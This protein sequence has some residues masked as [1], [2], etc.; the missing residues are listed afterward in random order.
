MVRGRP[1]GGGARRCWMPEPQSCLLARVQCTSQ[2]RRKIKN[3]DKVVERVWHSDERVY[4]I[5]LDRRAFGRASD[6]LG[7]HACST[8][9]FDFYG[10]GGTHLLAVLHAYK[11]TRLR[12]RPHSPLSSTSEHLRSGS[13]LPLSPPSRQ[14]DRYCACGSSLCSGHGVNQCESLRYA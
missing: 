2:F 9:C 14:C 4:L 1:G 5:P 11:S 3:A 12:Q 8:R 13:A 7:R 10:Y 6:G